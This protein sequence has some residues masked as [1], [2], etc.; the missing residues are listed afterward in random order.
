LRCRL[1]LPHA[2]CLDPCANVTSSSLPASLFQITYNDRPQFV[3]VGV[4]LLIFGHLRDTEAFCAMTFMAFSFV[5]LLRSS[6]DFG[7]ERAASLYGT[8]ADTPRSRRVM[9][10]DDTETL[11]LELKDGPYSESKT[12]T[13][14]WPVV[15]SFLQDRPLFRSVYERLFPAISVHGCAVETI[16]LVSS[17]S[18]ALSGISQ[19]MTGAGGPPRIIAYSVLDFS[20]GAIRGLTAMNLVSCLSL[21]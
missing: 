13:P 16:L 2:R 4:H 14:H 8:K 6:F 17:F 5:K 12:G 10:L 3:A 18:C 11:V 9:K 1:Q 20:K 15:Q 7:K 21:L 19:G